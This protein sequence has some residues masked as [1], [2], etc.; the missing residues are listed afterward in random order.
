MIQAFL[1]K[2]FG[3]SHERQLKKIQPRVNAINELEAKIQKLTDDQLRQRT[4]EMKE[5][6]DRGAK[7]DDMLIEAFAVCREA[8]SVPWACGT[9]TCSSSAAWCCTTARS[10]R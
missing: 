4:A 3:T 2:I 6:I 9:T 10:P 1:Q 8:A 5:K 7:L